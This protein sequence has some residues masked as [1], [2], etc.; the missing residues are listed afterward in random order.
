MTG[1]LKINRVIG[2]PDSDFQVNM[3][4]P[5]KSWARSFTR[6]GLEEFLLATVALDEEALDPI[7]DDLRMHG[8]ALLEEVHVAESELHASGFEQVPTDY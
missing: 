6:A 2:D 8:N 5:G 4:I 1:L 7:F 3:T